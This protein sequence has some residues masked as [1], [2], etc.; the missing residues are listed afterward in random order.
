[1]G[2][3]GLQF[4]IDNGDANIIRADLVSLQYTGMVLVS[5]VSRV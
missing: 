4:T 2:L 3:S 1:M 5:R